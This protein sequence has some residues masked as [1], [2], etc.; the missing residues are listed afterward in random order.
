[1]KKLLIAFEGIDGAGKWTQRE[2]TRDWLAGLGYV[3]M[4]GSEPNDDPD[5][6]TPLGNAIRNMLRG[7]PR[8]VRPK[9]PF[10]FQRDYVLDRAQDIICFINPFFSKPANRN[11]NLACLMERYALST[12]TYG[13]LSGRPAE[14]F[15]KLHNDVIGAQMLWP[16]ITAILDLSAEEAIRRIA[17]ARG[18]PEHF[19]KVETLTKVRKHYLEIAGHPYFRGK[20]AIV[21]GEG[22]EDEVFERVKSVLQP[23]LS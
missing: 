5:T 1:M 4:C 7:E 22:S 20:T 2:K 3:V 14:D 19:E 21:D 23:L 18:E 10:E 9:D 11:K 12:I 16:N 8:Y 6:G 15:I 13:M 17:K